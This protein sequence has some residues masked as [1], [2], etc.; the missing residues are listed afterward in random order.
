METGK[1]EEIH[2]VSGGGVWYTDKNDYHARR[3]KDYAVPRVRQ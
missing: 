3:R 1:S 2:L